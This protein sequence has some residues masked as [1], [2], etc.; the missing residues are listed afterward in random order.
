[1][2]PEPDERSGPVGEPLWLERSVSAGQVIAH[3]PRTILSIAVASVQAMCR[4][5]DTPPLVSDA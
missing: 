1:M 2:S 4:S 5:A 3:R